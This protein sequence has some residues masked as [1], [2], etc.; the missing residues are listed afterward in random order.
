MDGF[1]FSGGTTWDKGRIYD[2]ES[3]KTYKSKMTLAAPNRLE[4]RGYVGIPLF[5]RSTTWTR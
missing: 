5:G 1:T 3:G 2:P 4:I